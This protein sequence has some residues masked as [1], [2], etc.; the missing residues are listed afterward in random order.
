[1]LMILPRQI[2][3]REAG[4]RGVVWNLAVLYFD[5]V[6]RLPAAGEVELTQGRLKEG[7]LCVD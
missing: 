5:L 7:P 1:M 4:S 6:E 2:S 3:E